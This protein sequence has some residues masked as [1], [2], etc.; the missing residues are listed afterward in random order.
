MDTIFLRDIRMLHR[1]GG[2]MLPCAAQAGEAIETAENVYALIL[3][4][5]K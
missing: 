2:E 5:V 3:S 4:R 1:V